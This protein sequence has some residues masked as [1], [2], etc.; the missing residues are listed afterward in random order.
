MQLALEVTVEPSFDETSEELIE[1]FELVATESAKWLES[2]GLPPHKRVLVSYV[3]DDG[4][5]SP[6]LSSPRAPGQ[7]RRG[8]K[9]RKAGAR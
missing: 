8:R 2:M 5:A 3:D 1:T 6:L 9:P 4:K 7:P